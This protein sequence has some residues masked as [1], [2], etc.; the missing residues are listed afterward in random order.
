MFKKIFSLISAFVIFTIMT[1]IP[2]FAETEIVKTTVDVPPKIVFIGDSI[3]AG[4]GLEGYSDKDLY[5]C[6][7]YAV[8][9]GDEYTKVL[10]GICEEKM[11]N[12]AVSG[13]TS[14]QLL[15][16][17]E[18]GEFDKDFKD[19]DAVVISI[20]GNDILGIFLEFL[21]NDVGI[22]QDTTMDE[23]MD[24]FSDFFGIA[25]AYS[26]MADDM[27]NAIVEFGTNI[28]KIITAIQSRTDAQIIYQTQYD[29]L[30]SFKDI[31]FIKDLSAKE[32]GKINEEI[33]N[34]ATTDDGKQRYIIADIFTEFSG[35]SK[36][37]TNIDSFDIHP[38]AEGHKLISQIVDTA[39]RTQKYTYEQEV[40]IPESNSISQT[41]IFV[42]LSLF[43]LGILTLL[44]VLIIKR[45]RTRKN[46]RTQK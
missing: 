8:I 43:L 5:S 23:I 13:D 18:N 14:Q 42:V 2:C 32:I 6:Q 16:H 39:I 10:D 7:S 17:I 35:K 28:E 44:L 27:D 41:T 37:L 46:E 3:A 21:Q 36:E 45:N 12:D 20:G 22:T 4:Y 40:V 33:A 26:Q 1:A 34:H 11:I 29:P 24:K 19:S 9:L 30:D 38:N 25:R 31:P 15:S